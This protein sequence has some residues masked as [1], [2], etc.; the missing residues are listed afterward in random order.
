MDT[1]FRMQTGFSGPQTPKDD[2]LTTSSRIIVNDTSTMQVALTLSPVSVGDDDRPYTCS[3]SAT[4]T[5]QHVTA[6]DVIQ[7]TMRINVDG[8]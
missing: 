1:H 4:S 7:N 8:R 5:A 3:A 2:R 6:S